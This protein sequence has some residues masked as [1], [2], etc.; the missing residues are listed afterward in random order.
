M[1]ITAENY[2]SKLGIRNIKQLTNQQIY[3]LM[4][5]YAQAFYANKVQQIIVPNDTY[6]E[7]RKKYPDPPMIGDLP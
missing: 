3:D 1:I 7:K 6:S 4:E 5:N 2:A